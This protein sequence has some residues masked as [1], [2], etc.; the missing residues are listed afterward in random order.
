[1]DSLEEYEHG[2]W[3]A[4]HKKLDGPWVWRVPPRRVESL[5]IELEYEKPLFF[6]NWGWYNHS[7]EIRDELII[8][9]DKPYFWW[10]NPNNR[11][12]NMWYFICEKTF[13]QQHLRTYA[14]NNYL[15]GTDPN[16]SELPSFH[17]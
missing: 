10:I 2:F 5:D 14:Y 9:R 12:E 11:I 16:D 4:G 8:S 3:T 7:E 6:R 17:S 15:V 1:M 13:E